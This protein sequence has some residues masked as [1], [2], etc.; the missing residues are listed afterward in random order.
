MERLKGSICYLAGPIQFASDWGVGWRLKATKFLHSLGIGVIDPCDKPSDMAKEDEQ[1]Q[2]WLKSLKENYQYDE[3]TKFLKEV[4][5]IDLRF[6]DKS[7]F[8]LCYIDKNVYT[9]G[10]FHETSHAFIQRKPVVVFTDEDTRDIPGWLFG[11]TP[12][13]MFYSSLDDALKYIKSIN[14]DEQIDTLNRWKFLDF[15]KI[16]GKKI[17]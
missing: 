3:Y 13:K 8:L 2:V 1:T 17:F 6:V 5:S 14:E 4:V 10:T 11:H 12:H 9:C 7:D 16:Y 15:N